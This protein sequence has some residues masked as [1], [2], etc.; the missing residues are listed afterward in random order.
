MSEQ[1]ITVQNLTKKYV[2]QTA[3]QNVSF[4]IQKG[5]SVALLGANGAGKTTLFNIVLGLL[6]CDEGTCTVLGTPG[7]SIGH[8]LKERIGFISDESSPLPWASS[9]DIA[10]LYADL[11]SR[12]DQDNFQE[13]TQYLHIDTDKR[14]NTLSKGER[15]LT[16]IALVTSYHPELLILDEPFDGLDA[17]MRVKMEQL[18][19]RLNRDDQMTIFY[20]TH[21][22]AEVH[23]IA[24]RIII[25]KQGRLVCDRD[26][27]DA[28]SLVERSFLEMYE[29][30]IR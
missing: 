22:L 4:Q 23:K 15:R 5:E 21:I 7:R 20:S 26:I 8:A 9:S 10:R 25:L 18:L 14:L 13:V 16:E 28:P 30:D 19:N 24:R 29:K 3:L 11:Y 1:I 27:H 6:A 12:W 17:V 2:L